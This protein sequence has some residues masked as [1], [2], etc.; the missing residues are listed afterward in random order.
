T[1]RTRLARD[2]RFLSPVVPVVPGTRRTCRTRRVR[3]AC[4][5]RFLS[6]VV[7]VVPGTRRTGRTRNPCGAYMIRPGGPFMLLT[8]CPSSRMAAAVVAACLFVSGPVMPAYA[9]AA[10][11]QADRVARLDA[12]L[13]RYVEENRVAGLVAVVLR[14]GQVVYEHA[15]GWRDREANSPMQV[16]TIFRIASQTKALTSA[17]IMMLVEEGKVR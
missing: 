7:P 4:D 12:F 10:S 14:D 17:A 16:D 8:W 1:R 11:T 3:L 6:P 13:D 5:R 2:R 15:V 9:Q